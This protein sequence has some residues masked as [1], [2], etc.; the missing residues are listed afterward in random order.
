MNVGGYSGPHKMS[1]IVSVDSRPNNW[2]WS[3]LLPEGSQRLG[4]S[5]YKIFSKQHLHF[6]F[7]L[8]LAEEVVNV[9]KEKYTKQTKPGLRQTK[10]IMRTV[11][12]IQKPGIHPPHI[13]MNTKFQKKLH[14]RR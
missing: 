10:Q 8:L 4:R 6:Y 5:K 11:N 1:L 13:Y 12:K 3:F 7:Y 14:K 2:V 9:N